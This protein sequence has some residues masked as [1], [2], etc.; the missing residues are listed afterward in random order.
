MEMVRIFVGER[1]EGLWSVKMLDQLQ[2]EF[3]LFFSRVNDRKW[4]YDFFDRNKSDL[5]GGFYRGISIDDAVIK[6]LDELEEMED[7]LYYYAEQ[8][9]K[10]KSSTL[11]HLFRPLNNYEYF[12]SV[13]Q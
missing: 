10:D 4:L 6:T 1:E 13:H 3:R 12:I 9:F 8:G 5:Y 2:D 7:M 11:Q